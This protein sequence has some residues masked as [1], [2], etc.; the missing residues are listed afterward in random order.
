MAARADASGAAETAWSWLDGP[1]ARADVAGMRR[2]NLSLVVQLLQAAG[3][4]TTRARLA[5][6]SGLTKATVSSL[7]NE[8]VDRR[9]VHPGPVERGHV[10]R[11][12]QRLGL[13]SGSVAALGIEVN[14]DY[15]AG[16]VLDLDGTLRAERR[17]ALDAADRGFEAALDAIVE[18]AQEL[19]AEVDERAMHLAGLAVAVPGLVDTASGTVA[20]APNLGWR[21]VPV[22]EVLR[23]RLGRR[24]LVVR[25]DNDANLSA[26]AEHARGAVPGCPDMLYLTGEV[27]VGA[28]L[29]VGGR[30][31]RGSQG[32]SG[33]VGHMPLDP[34][35]HPCGCGRRGCWETVVGLAALLRAAADPDDPVRD[36]GLDLDTRL[37]EMSRRA[38]AGD[39]RTLRALADIGRSLGIGASLLVNV[40]N[41]RALVL[42]GYFAVMAPYLMPSL[43]RELDERVV[44]PDA[45]GVEVLASTLGFSAASLGAAQLALDG[46]LAD[47]TVIPVASTA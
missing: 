40:L 14:V 45:A 27:G 13:A 35:G 21:D 29:I 30:L 3:G 6:A 43:R 9:L 26:L 10:G 11:P 20:F 4:S 18:Q 41:P 34:L 12:G 1:P 42:G 7:V 5:A 32:F 15:V 38:D 22:A 33:E 19:V 28:G 17:V 16:V 2:A 39:G 46:V 24:G 47:P 44:A 23:R 36:P 25:V 31:M 8:L 37:A